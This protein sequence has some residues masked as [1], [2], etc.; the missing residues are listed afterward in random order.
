M[1]DRVWQ[2]A[3]SADGSELR[4][5]AEVVEITHLVDLSGWPAGCRMIARRDDPHPGAQLTFTD[6]DG[7]RLQVFVTDCT[8][9]DIS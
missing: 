3:I 4:E 5:H 7:H 8:D 6:V 9:V 1:P 2:P